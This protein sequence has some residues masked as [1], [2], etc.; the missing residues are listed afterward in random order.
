MKR[1]KR[2]VTL[3]P[4]CYCGHPSAIWIGPRL[5]CSRC[6]ILIREKG[7]RRT[8]ES[9]PYV[10]VEMTG[11]RPVDG[12]KSVYKVIDPVLAKEFYDKYEEEFCD[13]DDCC[14]GRYCSDGCW[15]CS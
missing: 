10:N 8:R 4:A 5:H 14:N 3:T 6:S 1:S 9:Y 15:K 13:K 7:K 11:L 2:V 12:V